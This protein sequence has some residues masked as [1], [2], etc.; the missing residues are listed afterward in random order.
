MWYAGATFVARGHAFR[1]WA[2]EAAT[3]LVDRFLA[4][5]DLP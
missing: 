2:W 3:G 1:T 5:Y 4:S